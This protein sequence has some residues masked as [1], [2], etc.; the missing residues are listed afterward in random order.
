MWPHCGTYY[1]NC[2]V[3]G[4]FTCQTAYVTGSSGMSYG[5]QTLLRE[6]WVWVW[7]YPQCSSQGICRAH[8][9]VRCCIKLLT[10]RYAKNS[11]LAALVQLGSL[12]TVAWLCGC[13]WSCERK[14]GNQLHK[15]RYGEWLA[16]HRVQAG[17]LCCTKLF[18]GLHVW[19]HY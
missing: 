18:V 8:H 11:L 9:Q 4:H 5:N 10:N 7:D 6:G 1:S 15:G 3:I 14:S 19:N 12:V 13:Q 17:K 2:A 16:L